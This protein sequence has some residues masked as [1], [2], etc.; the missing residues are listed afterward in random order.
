[1][2]ESRA[3]RTKAIT[4]RAQAAAGRRSAE[5]ALPRGMR[6]FILLSVMALCTAGL[7]ARLAYWQVLQHGHLTAVAL[8]EEAALS[9]QPALRGQI[10]D[11]AG[12]ILATDVTKDFVYAAPKKIVN[13]TRTAML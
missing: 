2:L 6:P 7:V 4:P 10:F 3:A 13:P 5:T 9:V 8:S 11:D 12:N 1:M